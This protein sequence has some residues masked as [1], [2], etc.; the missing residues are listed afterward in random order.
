MRRVSKLWKLLKVASYRDALRRHRVAAAVEHASVLGQLDFSFVVDVGA[1]R[2]QFTLFAL[3]TF[4]HAQIVSLEPLSAPA[5][6]ASI[7]VRATRTSPHVMPS[8]NE[9][10]ASSTTQPTASQ[11]SPFLLVSVVRR[12][13][14]SQLRPPSEATHNVPAESA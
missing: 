5:A 2:G 4:P 14:F 1:N 9:C 11:G 13:F 7:A 6:Q 10:A 12:P 8:H 3:R